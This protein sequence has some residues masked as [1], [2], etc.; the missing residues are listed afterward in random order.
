MKNWLVTLILLLG[1]LFLVRACYQDYERNKFVPPQR[2]IRFESRVNPNQSGLLVTNTN[3][4]AWPNPTF[5]IN[6][7]Y[8]SNRDG[9]VRGG[10]IIE[11]PFS[12]F[13]N[14]QGVPFRDLALFHSFDIKT[15]TMVSTGKR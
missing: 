5:I 12:S 4:F 6:G 14:D 1:I 13:Q 9:A 10:E 15:A 3:D 8:R 7:A 11:V 2:T